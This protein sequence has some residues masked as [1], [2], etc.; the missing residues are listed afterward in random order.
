MI[1]RNITFQHHIGEVGI[2]E[3]GIALIVAERCVLMFEEI[4]I[5]DGV[6][7]G[8]VAIIEQLTDVY[9]FLEV[10]VWFLLIALVSK[11]AIHIE[12]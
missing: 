9:L 5:A 8:R 4:G 3:P 10:Y 2:A 12:K 7:I 11:G 6:A 1:L